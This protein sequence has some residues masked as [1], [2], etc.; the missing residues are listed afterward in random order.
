[1]LP[2]LIVNLFPTNRKYAIRIDLIQSY[3]EVYSDETSLTVI[4]FDGGNHDFIRVNESVK[5]ISKT[6]STLSKHVGGK[7]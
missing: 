4:N 2:F 3:Y 6:L 5:E 7:Q 1:M